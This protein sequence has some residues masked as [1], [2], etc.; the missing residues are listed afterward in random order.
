MEKKLRKSIQEKEVQMA[1]LMKHADKSSF[2]ADLYNKIVLEKAILKKEL[3]ELD[4]NVFA[5]NIKRL[6]PRKKVYISDYFKE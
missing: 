4:K 2:C 5:E 1:K 3:D 6:M